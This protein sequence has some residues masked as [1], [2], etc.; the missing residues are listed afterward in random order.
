MLSYLI[1]KDFIDDD[2]VGE[3]E[4]LE[5]LDLVAKGCRGPDGVSGTISLLKK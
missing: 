5:V 2:H 3:D 1:I 4:L